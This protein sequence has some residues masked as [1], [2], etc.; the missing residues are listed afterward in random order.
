M[1][2]DGDVV[3]APYGIARGEVLERLRGGADA[4][5]KVLFVDL[6]GVV[7]VDHH[8]VLDAGRDRNDGNALGLLRQ[9]VVDE[10]FHVER[11]GDLP[12]TLRRDHQAIGSDTGRIPGSRRV[13]H[14][15]R[16]GSRFLAEGTSVPG[17][18]G[19]VAH[20]LHGTNVSGE[21][22]R[23]GAVVPWTASRVGPLAWS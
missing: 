23:P 3:Q 8:Q 6:R 14:N 21:R 11:P 12:C 5:A 10:G 4:P 20:V 9:R 19:S 16:F 7:S 18:K 13:L 2:G 22:E 17:P 15:L 1:S